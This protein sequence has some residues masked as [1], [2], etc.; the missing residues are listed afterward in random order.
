MYQIAEIKE[1]GFR[2]LI[3][4]VFL[5]QNND[6]IRLYDEVLKDSPHINWG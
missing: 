3:F 1:N 2:K 4:F 5:S 6:L